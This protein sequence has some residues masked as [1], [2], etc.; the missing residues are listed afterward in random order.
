MMRSLMYKCPKDDEELIFLYVSAEGTEIYECE[1]YG[2]L[3]ELSIES[4]I[5]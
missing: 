2:Q 4:E 5:L 1:Y 3:I